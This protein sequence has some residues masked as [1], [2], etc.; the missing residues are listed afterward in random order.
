[1]FRAL[2]A[3]GVPG[4]DQSDD[5]KKEARKDG[6]EDSSNR[7]ELR[8]PELLVEKALDGTSIKAADLEGKNSAGKFA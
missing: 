4:T 6:N 1:M 3:L 7:A 2:E 5:Y 8:E